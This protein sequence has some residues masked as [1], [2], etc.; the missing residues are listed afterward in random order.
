[1]KNLPACQQPSWTGTLLHLLGSRTRDKGRVRAE[2]IIFS[3]SHKFEA[4]CRLAL[5]HYI[6]QVSQSQRQGV[7]VVR[8]PKTRAVLLASVGMQTTASQIEATACI[9]IPYTRYRSQLLPDAPC[10]RAQLC[11][12]SRGTITHYGFPH[13][14]KIRTP[15]QQPIF[16]LS[17]LVKA[18]LL[19]CR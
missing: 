8:L 19:V 4:Y 3:V 14:L 17:P 10:K 1:M 13:L 2:V 11:W 9:N 6:W 18:L 16:Q 15:L 5:G 12:R 7:H